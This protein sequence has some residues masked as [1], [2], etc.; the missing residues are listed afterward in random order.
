MELITYSYA[1]SESRDVIPVAPALHVQHSEYRRA[2]VVLPR[3][4]VE[5]YRGIFSYADR[6][7]LLRLTAI[8]HSFCNE[9]EDVLYT[10][11]SLW[12]SLIHPELALSWCRAVIA[13]PRR[14]LHVNTLSFP[15]HLKA[16]L[17]KEYCDD[18]I[19][20]LIR[21]AFHAIVNLRYFIFLP[22]ERAISSRSPS[23]DTYG[24][25]F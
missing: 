18:D 6:E 2:S 15:P 3:L 5:L 11:I 23:L 1:E 12:S 4:P 20:Q 10:N 17:M 13:S 16:S 21:K 7:T 19:Q 8:S 24:L 25:R 9:A 22:H 14:A